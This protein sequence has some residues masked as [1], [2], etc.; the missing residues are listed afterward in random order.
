MAKLHLLYMLLVKLGSVHLKGTF[1][2]SSVSAL[3]HVH[4]GQWTP[5]PGLLRRA[6]W[7]AQSHA[8]LQ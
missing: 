3:I 2:G 7:H 8:V 5:L 6:C 1:R 4:E